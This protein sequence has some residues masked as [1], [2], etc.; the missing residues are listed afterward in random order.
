MAARVE[1]L[2]RRVRHFD[3]V[4]HHDAKALPTVRGACADQHD[5]PQIGQ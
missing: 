1:V 5:D 2:R 4:C 3:R